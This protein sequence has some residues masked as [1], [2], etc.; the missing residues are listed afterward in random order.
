MERLEWGS[1]LHTNYSRLGYSF[2][3]WPGCAL[4]L[5]D[6]GIIRS[7]SFRVSSMM[8]KKK[9]AINMTLCV[10]IPHILKQETGDIS[11]TNLTRVSSPLPGNEKAFQTNVLIDEAF[12][13]C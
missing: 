11:R 5:R 8:P 1:F 10:K 2:F 9:R 12:R 7:I 13:G 4:S 6:V 3:T